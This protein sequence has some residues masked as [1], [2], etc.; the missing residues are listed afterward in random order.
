MT[1]ARVAEEDMMSLLT[2]ASRKT[3]PGSPVRKQTLW[4][5]HTFT[6]ISHS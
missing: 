4:G 5:L 1:E 3:L 2:R 6:V